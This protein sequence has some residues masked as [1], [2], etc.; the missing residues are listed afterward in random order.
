MT[1]QTKQMGGWGLVVALAGSVLGIVIPIF[2]IVF[3]TG[4]VIAILAYMR[5]SDE[6]SEPAIKNNVITAL[7]LMIV[8]WVVMFLSGGAMIAGVMTAM[9][10]EG[11]MGMT[12][13]GIG[14]LGLI[15]AWILGVVASWFWYKANR[16]MTQ[17]SGVNLFKIGGLLF[18]IGEILTVIFVGSLLI[19]A[20][21]IVLIVAWF[22][23]QEEV[24]EAQASPS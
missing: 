10:G 24:G 16:M 1:R 19:L 20:G 14:L 17:K 2:W 3:L 22:S 15:V 21:L 12:M 5:A 7:I 8:Y 23:V 4:W 6:Y 11:H 9:V 18:F 13:G